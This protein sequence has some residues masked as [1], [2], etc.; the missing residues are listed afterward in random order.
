[1]E[2]DKRIIKDSDFIK[3]LELCEL[4]LYKDGDLAWFLLIPRLEGVIDWTDLNAN[5]QIILT[6]EI[7]YVCKMLKKFN[8]PDKINIGSLG[9]MVPQMHIHIIGRMKS[10]RS[11]PG[12]IWGT[13]SKKTYQAYMLESWKKI[14]R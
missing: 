13:K 4:R 7:D 2:I 14:F 10:D 5:Q 1:M 9:N 6:Q 3:Q 12:A 11:W 8:N